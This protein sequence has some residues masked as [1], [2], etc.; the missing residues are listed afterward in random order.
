MH[1]LSNG[2]GIAMQSFDGVC[3]SYEPGHAVNPIQA[4]VARHEWRYTVIVFR[5][6]PDQI[7]LIGEHQSWK[8]FNHSI[9][10]IIDQLEINKSAIV[11]YAPGSKVLFISTYGNT[12]FAYHMSTEPISSCESTSV[13]ST[14]GGE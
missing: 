5:N 8:V 1:F 9:Q 11:D 10:S 12:G 14:E 13:L 3:R 6:K 2:D 4:R 7:T